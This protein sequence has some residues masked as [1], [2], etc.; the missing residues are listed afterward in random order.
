[1]SEWIIEKRDNRGRCVIANNP[2]SPGDE[3]QRNESVLS[4][5]HIER[6]GSRCNN[7]F[8]SKPVKHCSRCHFFAYCCKECQQNDWKYHKK[9]CK[10]IANDDVKM[11]L[12]SH[13][14]ES[15]NYSVSDILLTARGHWNIVNNPESEVKPD[16]PISHQH[17]NDTLKIKFI[18]IDNFSSSLSYYYYCYYYYYYY[19]NILRL[20]IWLVKSMKVIIMDFKHFGVS[21]VSCFHQ[22]I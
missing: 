5:L 21:R 8:A 18:Q 7:C 6:F 3:V 12:L 2:F 10:H 22:R 15:A 13:L 16:T 19:I 4:M 1:M 9:E 17:I 11:D 20:L 14:T